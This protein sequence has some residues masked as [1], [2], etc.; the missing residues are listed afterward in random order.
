MDLSPCAFFAIL[1]IFVI[2]YL[3]IVFEHSIKL[4]KSA[5]ALTIAALCWSVYFTG[6]TL[7]IN[8]DMTL[9]GHYL[10][11]ISQIIFFLMGAMTLV[12]MVDTHK[13]FTLITDLIQ[14][15]STRKLLWII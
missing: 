3:G 15:S 4:N 8:D 9:F 6:S 14:T 1:A 13:G 11:D 2:G 5:V 7:P 10:S 12:E